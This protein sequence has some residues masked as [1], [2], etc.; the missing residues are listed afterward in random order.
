MK[1]S[2]RDK[3]LLLF[4]LIV[5]VVALPISL[6][7]VPKMEETKEL[8]AKNE[9]LQKRVDELQ[10]L[11]DKKGYYETSINAMKDAEKK[12]LLDFDEGLDQE[13]VIMFIRNE[14]E[15][16]PFIITGLNFGEA[17]TAVLAPAKFDADGKQTEGLEFIEKQTNIEFDATYAQ[18]K[19]FLKSIL[20]QDEKM[21][22]VGVKA[23]Y[24]DENGRL[25]GTFVL[26]QYAFISADPDRKYEDI[27]IPALKHGNV[28]KGGI[29][30]KYIS[31]KKIR[32]TVYG[33]DAD[34]AEE[35]TEE[36]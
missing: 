16:T 36:E 25:K 26:E 23:K 22:L 10:V 5:A 1:I 18:M 33:P 13:N 20:E 19:T 4:L 3:K 11:Y 14:A 17:V 2:N 21:A 35:E 8:K 15:K 30:G 28:D 27:Q 6:F 31:N 32:E 29:F 24:D 34:A 7:F 12:L 9:A